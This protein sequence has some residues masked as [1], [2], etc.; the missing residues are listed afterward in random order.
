MSSKASSSRA[1]TSE[2]VDI[3]PTPRILKLLGDIE[4]EP[5][6]CIAE[7]IDNGF[8]EF[9]RIKRLKQAWNEPF[10]VAVSLPSQ[11]AND[12]Q[13]MI[14]VRDNGRGMTLDQVTDAVRAGWT[15]ND[16]LG[17]LG[18]F[19]MGFNIA[20]ARLGRVARI[21]TTRSEDA[22]WVGVEIDLDRIGPDFAAPV[23]RQT[24]S[25][26]GEHGTRVEV[27]SLYPR[28]EW[29]KR[30][31]NQRKLR[32]TLGGIYSYLLDSQRFKLT[33]RDVAVK[34][35]RH[36]VWDM[37]RTV[38][39]NKEVIPTVI[40]IN[41]DLADR[42]VCLA[43]ATWQ[44]LGS[45]KCESCGSDHLEVRE[46]RI[47]GWV[48]IQRY[49]DA[50]EFGVDFLRNGRKILRFDK[51]IFQWTDPDDPSVQVVEYPIELAHQG[52]RLVGE[53]HL[54]HVPV[55]YTKDSFE[56]SDKS[57]RDAVRIVRG[58]GPLLPETAKRLGIE[59]NSPL[60]RLH[61]G[62]RRND[63]GLSY[64]VPGNGNTAIHETAREWGRKFREGDIDYQNDT[65]WWAAVLRHEELKAK[66]KE[67]QEKRQSAQ[68][69]QEEDP[70]A[71]FT[72]GAEPA[73]TPPPETTAPPQT[74]R[75]RVELLMASATPMPELDGQFTATGV[76]G[77]PVKLTAYQVSHER[78]KTP[79]G[80]LTP[81][82][83]AQQRGGFAAFVDMKHAHFASFDDD[84]ADL[85]M[86]ELAAHLIARAQGAAPPI[87]AVFADLKQRYLVS[88]TIDESKLAPLAMQLMRDVKDRAVTCVAENP[89][90]PWSNVLNDAERTIT[91]D[92]LATMAGVSN[93]DGAVMEGAYLRYVPET[94]VPRIVEEWP[95]AF[96]DGK[97]FRSP[98]Q[99]I[100][101]SSARRQIVAT[102]TGY[103]NDV[104]WLA[105]TPDDVSRERLIRAR[106]SLQLL[107][108]E[109]ADVG[110]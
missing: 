5:W 92:R 56:R 10:E 62:F 14:V 65:K 80:K 53:I 107:P 71:E 42:S 74:E 105:Q 36:C 45:S 77:R 12:D 106:L 22:E 97:L 51:T 87:S 103:L 6:Q 2:F 17:N 54:D 15:T 11:N 46:R 69:T 38:T 109:I 108:E 91:G 83:L 55:N 32:E 1:A 93:L 60:A 33:V 79:E 104:A 34:P 31:N 28:A 67:E 8:D 86:M 40:E 66:A 23:V 95:E 57:W 16:P 96:L 44:D 18:L 88:R 50:N 78:V 52:G 7:L 64:L 63:P 102:I 21:L 81:V 82:L 76:A 68:A 70:T 101:S 43:C 84:P 35:I 85:V 90:R 48:G 30:S 20:T 41:K 27:G 3:T 61:R 26:R 4:F 37:S 72:D 49:L 47:W 13:A 25:S 110:E 75:E 24:K 59:N 58:E 73:S 29:L 100:G 39:R 9:L 89:E 99:E 98:Y 94:V 19:G